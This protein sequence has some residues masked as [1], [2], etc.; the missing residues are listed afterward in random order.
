MARLGIVQLDD[1]LLL[2]GIQTDDEG[3]E[4][5]DFEGLAATDDPDLQRDVTLQ[6][7]VDWQYFKDYGCFN[8]EHSNAPEDWVGVPLEVRPDA[9]FRGKKG[10]YV[11]GRLFLKQPRARAIYDTMQAIKAAKTHRRMGLSIQGKVLV[12]DPL[13]RRNILR[14]LVNKISFTTN[15]VN[16]VTEVSLLKGLDGSVGISRD[17]WRELVYDHLG[18][19]LGEK[20]TEVADALFDRAL[21]SP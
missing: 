8:W 4:Y 20:T 3:N 16:T 18:D 14:S 5:A 1:E 7:G 17:S 15:P 19:L 21:T 9:V 11:K 6:G 2:K 10:T 12:R 13:N